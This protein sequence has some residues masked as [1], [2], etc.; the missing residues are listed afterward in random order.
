VNRSGR[1]SSLQQGVVARWN[2]QGEGRSEGECSKDE[3][4][5]LDLVS[6]VLVGF[7]VLI[8]GK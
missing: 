6:W 2:K 8:K 7:F 5:S 4:I 3:G 1:L